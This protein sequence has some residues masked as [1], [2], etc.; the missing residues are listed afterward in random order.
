MTLPERVMSEGTDMVLVEALMSEVDLQEMA[1]RMLDEA[2]ADVVHADQ[3]SSVLL[4]ALGIGFGAVLGGQLSGGWDSSCLSAGSE[5]LWWVGVAGA[6][7]SVVASAFAVWPRYKIDDQPKYGVT[8]WG[9]AGAFDSPKALQK[10]LERQDVTDMAR[11][12]HQLWSLSRVVLKKYR[13][14]RL[15]LVLAGASGLMLGLAAVV[16]R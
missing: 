1:Q 5:I 13:F 16:L 15:A 12:S 14:V 4:A 2:R 8:Y 10:A 3:K 9:H 7:L 6:V 11:T